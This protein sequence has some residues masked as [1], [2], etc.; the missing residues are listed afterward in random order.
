M[1]QT[2][3]TVKLTCPGC[4]RTVAAR[5]DELGEA[6]ECP[7]C[8]QPFEA[9][10]AVAKPRQAST[11]K[12]FHFQCLRCGSVL[13]A[14]SGQ[15]GHEGKCPTCGALF[16]IPE[17]DPRTGLARHNADPGNDGENPTPV[18]AYAAAGAM[19][20]RIIRQQD[21]SLII[22]CPRCEARSPI[23]ANNCPICGLP[24]T[25]EGI[26][27]TAVVPGSNK[28]STALLI[29]CAGLPLSFCGIGILP[30]AVAVVQAIAALSDRFSS[31]NLLAWLALAIAGLDT[32]ICLM[33]WLN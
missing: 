31:G 26:S 6:V 3:E 28:A 25:M 1:A 16:T 11:G 2:S 19:A 22:E 8:H 33:V 17:V 7:L 23:T 12:P 27:A 9:S 14:R 30:A 18:H 13:E 29:A 15:S 21:D 10:L 24:F 20:P 32:F 4:G 5:L